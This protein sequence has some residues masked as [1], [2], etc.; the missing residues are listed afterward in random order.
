MTSL[1]P[2]E[3]QLCSVCSLLSL[4]FTT[5]LV[6]NTSDVIVLCK[7][8][9]SSIP[10]D[11]QSKEKYIFQKENAEEELE[12]QRRRELIME[13]AKN[14]MRTCEQGEKWSLN[15]VRRC[16]NAINMETFG[17]SH[18]LPFTGREVKAL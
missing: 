9:Y 17:M 12:F 10:N 16:L 14:E 3:L 15:Q 8:R 7:K 18:C 5:V 2:L 1:L 6:R 13:K 11:S 4:L